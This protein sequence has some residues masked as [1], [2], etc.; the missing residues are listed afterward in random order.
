LGPKPGTPPSELGR[1][2]LG[3]L[4][5]VVRGFDWLGMV[6][7][8][9]SSAIVSSGGYTSMLRAKWRFPV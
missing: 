8:P 6:Y 2:M 3:S 5:E 7:I 9:D 1:S 4:A